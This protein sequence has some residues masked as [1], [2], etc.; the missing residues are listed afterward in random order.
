MMSLAFSNEILRLS[1]K[2]TESVQ[3]RNINPVISIGSWG[4][5]NSS[6]EE[7]SRYTRTWK[8]SVFL[9]PL[10]GDEVPP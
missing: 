10:L 2:K 6:P 1:L 5:L 8:E 7:I 3:I 9:S 4:L